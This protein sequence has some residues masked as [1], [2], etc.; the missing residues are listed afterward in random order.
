MVM[1]TLLNRISAK[2][3]GCSRECVWQFCRCI[4]VQISVK[5]ENSSA[6]SKGS[7]LQQSP[8]GCR[9]GLG[10]GHRRHHCAKAYGFK[11]FTLMVTLNAGNRVDFEISG[12]FGFAVEIEDDG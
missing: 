11:T 12:R 6:Q 5:T 4:G 9:W 8:P 1:V 2:M 10:F 3:S 7:G